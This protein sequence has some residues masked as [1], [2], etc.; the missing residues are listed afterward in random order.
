[1]HAL[2]HFRESL[3]TGFESNQNSL[4]FTRLLRGNDCS[5]ITDGSEIGSSSST[6]REQVVE[7]QYTESQQ[8]SNDDYVDHICIDT[9]HVNNEIDDMDMQEAVIDEVGMEETVID[10]E[11]MEEAVFS[12]IG[13]SQE[14]AEKIQIDTMQQSNSVT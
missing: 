12:H 8:E 10:A 11:N 5:L 13:I 3:C 6:I 7:P 4:T 2:H 9:D 14:T 1:M